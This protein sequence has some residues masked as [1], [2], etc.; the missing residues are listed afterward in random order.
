MALSIKPLTSGLS[1]GERPWF[2]ARTLN[3]TFYQ[4]GLPL[5]VLACSLIVFLIALLKGY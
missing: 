3:D 1:R 4:Y 2:E 5:T